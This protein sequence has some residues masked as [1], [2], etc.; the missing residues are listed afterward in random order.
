M[1]YVANTVAKESS[2]QITIVV[3]YSFMESDLRRNSIV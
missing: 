1:P 2:R 3:H